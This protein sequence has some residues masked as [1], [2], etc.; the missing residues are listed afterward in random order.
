M[1][2]EVV[3]GWSRTRRRRRVD[4][5]RRL[6]TPGWL[7]G[8][9]RKRNQ[10]VLVR[11]ASLAERGRAFEAIRLLTESNR[12][13]RNPDVEER[14]ISLRHE[15]V[16]QRP[17]ARAGRVRTDI[18]DPFPEVVTTPPEVSA[19]DLTGDVLTGCIRH[20]GCVVVRGLIPP[21]RVDRLVADVDRAMSVAYGPPGSDGDAN[22][23]Y[24]PFN[25]PAYEVSENERWFVREMNAIWATDSPPMFFDLMEAFEEAGIPAVV[26]EHF[27]EPPLL[28]AQKCAA[29]RSRVRPGSLAASCWHQDGRFLGTGVRAVNVWLSLSHCGVDAPSLDLIPV[30]LNE[31]VESGT[32]DRYP[33]LGWTIGSAVVEAVSAERGRPSVRPIFR[34]GDALLFDELLL[35]QTGADPGMTKTRYSFECWFTAAS[36]YPSTQWIP[37]VC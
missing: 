32:G 1:S 28:T 23:W 9:A 10:D 26:T 14:L 3:F 34:P 22:D 7:V 37:L 16:L 2:Q 5:L 6:Y 13:E 29:A 4:E 8:Q 31:Y 21:P 17:K 30:Q 11:A 25:F 36:T 12:R 33:G 20:H 19:R 27:G 35:H 24:R 18:A 15:A